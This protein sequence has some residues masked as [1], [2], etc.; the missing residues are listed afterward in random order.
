MFFTLSYT[1]LNKD[2]NEFDTNSQSIEVPS[3]KEAKAQAYE[4]AEQT[5]FPVDITGITITRRI[6]PSN[7]PYL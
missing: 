4:L 2:T 5:R 6:F 1:K 7:I 3:F